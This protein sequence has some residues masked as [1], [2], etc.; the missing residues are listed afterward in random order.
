MPY[1]TL[2]RSRSQTF[3]LGMLKHSLADEKRAGGGADVER[4]IV[5]NMSDNAPME[6]ARSHQSPKGRRPS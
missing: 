6:T 3:L 5:A 1:L 4:E 2:S